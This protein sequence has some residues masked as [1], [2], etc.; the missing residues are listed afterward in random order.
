MEVRSEIN[1]LYNTRIKVTTKL[2]IFIVRISRMFGA[3]HHVMLRIVLLHLPEHG[4][5]LQLCV[6][7]A[8][9]VQSS[10]PWAGEGV[11]QSLVRL[12]SPPPHVTLQAPQSLQPPQPPLTKENNS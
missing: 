7:E 2:M 1:S 6:S 8:E 9:P 11:S 10:P 5:S 12:W 3:T 4:V